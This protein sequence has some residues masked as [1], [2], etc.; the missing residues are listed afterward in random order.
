MSAKKRWC[1]AAGESITSQQCGQDREERYLCPLDCEYLLEA[2]RHEKPP[3]VDPASFPHRDV[4]V[5]E[6]FVRRNQSLLVFTARTV[7]AAALEADATDADVREALEALIQTYRTRESGLIYDTRP[8][9]PY[10][11]RI[12]ERL[13]ESF[14]KLDEEIRQQTGM[15]T[16]RD[17]DVLGILVFVQSLCIQNGNGRRRGRR[18]Q[19][20]LRSYF[21]A[22]PNP[23]EPEESPLTEK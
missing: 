1:P 20:F 21:P 18:F 6:E 23:A 17:A 2:R 19:D 13:R 3:G 7:A 4:K 22:A 10:A 15:H 12:C 9:N 16:L 8:A 14:G 5:S 11:A